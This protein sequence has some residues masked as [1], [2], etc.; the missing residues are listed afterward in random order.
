M[1]GAGPVING[2]GHLPSL[3][4]GGL[5]ERRELPNGVWSRVLVQCNSCLGARGQP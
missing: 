3:L 1:I 4:T 2:T 5:G